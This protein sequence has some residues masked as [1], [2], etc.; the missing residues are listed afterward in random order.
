MGLCHGRMLH[1]RV[2]QMLEGCCHGFSGPGLSLRGAGPC[3]AKLAANLLWIFCK[4]VKLKRSKFGS[5]IM[6][7]DLKL[8]NHGPPPIRFS[9]VDMW[10]MFDHATAKLLGFLDTAQDHCEWEALLCDQILH[11]IATGLV[12]SSMLD[13]SLVPADT[14]PKLMAF[15][16][17]NIIGAARVRLQ[18]AVH[19]ELVRAKAPTSLFQRIAT[20]LD[21]VDP[22]MFLP[23]SLDVWGQAR[24]LALEATRA[25]HSVD[26]QHQETRTNFG[27]DPR[28]R[29][30]QQ[31]VHDH[32]IA[33]A[34]LDKQR[35]QTD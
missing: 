9:P 27:Q 18:S 7:V 6:D 32:A 2:L 22:S 25:Y 28:A 12:L 16:R 14:D 4:S 23:K 35:T 8:D 5:V 19:A 24:A 21:V 33:Q 34:K 26:A 13:P 30:Q 29:A 1:N 11:T 10:S 15:M 31:H 17:D 20:Y 3:G